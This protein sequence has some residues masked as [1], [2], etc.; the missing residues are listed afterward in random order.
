MARRPTSFLVD[1]DI[2][3][4][5]LNGVQRMREILDIPRYRVYYS[6]VTQKELLAKRGLSAAERQ[7]IYTLLRHHRLIPVDNKI[8]ER[9]SRLLTTYAGQDLRK[10]DALV[11]ATAWSQKLPLFTRNIK[12]YRFMSEITL[13]DAAEL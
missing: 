7:K 8:A 2:F 5:Y 13:L 12:H 11:T 3:I 9:F 6:A 4:D 10:A 1:T